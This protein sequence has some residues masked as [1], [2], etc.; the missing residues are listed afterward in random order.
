M[1]ERLLIT[2]LIPALLALGSPWLGGLKN[3]SPV[4]ETVSL[5]TQ[6]SQLIGAVLLGVTTD[7]NEIISLKR[8]APDEIAAGETFTIIEELRAKVDLDG[9]AVVSALPPGFQLVSG[10]LRGFA[11]KTATGGVFTNTYQVKA[12]EVTG[13]YTITANV[14]A[15][16]TGKES[17][18]MTPK[19]LSIQVVPANMLPLAL[20][21][22]SP[23][24]VKALV[25]DTII[26]NATTSFDLDGEIVDYRWD[27]GDGTVVNGPER[28][29]VEHSYAEAGSYMV[30]LVVIDNE[31]EASAPKLQRV[32]VREPEKESDPR[33]QNALLA[34]A[35]VAA[36]MGI[37]YLIWKLFLS[38]GDASS[39]ADSS[40]S[41]QSSTST[42]T[43]NS[44]AE[45]SQL[46]VE[47]A[48]SRA[49][50][51]IGDMSLPLDSIAEVHVVGEVTEANRVQWINRL[52]EK[53]LL[54]KTESDESLVFEAY[55]D[56]AQET[57]R[58]IDRSLSPY[59][60]KSLKELLGM[61]V[62]AG[63]SIAEITWVQKN[64]EKFESLAVVSPKGFVKFDTFMTLDP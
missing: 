50:E 63:D 18:A 43:R 36:A 55:L 21:V 12:P 22:P 52:E 53:S 28:T 4:N 7:E 11:N 1:L 61:K 60:A 42:S 38:D 24:N 64:G 27:L 45:I 51:F 48:E 35:G 17:Q 16:P 56:L 19:A 15:K 10:D 3:Q 41:S 2:L 25:G 33:L 47:A 62:A 54:I 32:T 23:L 31:Q 13:V 58:V 9:A 44:S 8:T 40:A 14:R 5:K 6:A 57:Q 59:G 37:G 30:S 26:F 39:T 29:I 34:T 20:F 46:P 49:E